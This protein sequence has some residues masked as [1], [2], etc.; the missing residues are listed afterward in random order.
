[1]SRPR[2]LGLAAA[3]LLLMVVVPATTAAA[4]PPWKPPVGARW[5]YQLNGKIRTDLCV[6]PVSGGAC[7]RPEVYDVDLYNM[8][9]TALNT[10]SVAQIHAAGAHAVCYVSAGSF[11]SFRPDAAAF[12]TS[13]KGKSNGWPGEKWLDIRQIP[14][15]LPI[16]A[17]R[18]DLCVAAG[19]DA[20][21]FD[22]V[23]GY[24]NDTGFP[25]TAS[26]QFAYN[27]VLTYVAHARGLSVGLK[28]DVEQAEALQ[29]YFDFAI[30]EQ[31]AQYS[32]CGVYDS[33]TA[34]GKAVLQVEYTKK[35][36]TFC[37]AAQVGGRSTIKKGLALK[38]KPW[39][40]CA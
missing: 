36:A 1:V 34:A 23:D 3:A 27:W 2:L 12:P 37:P 18:V 9:G 5:Q 6:V 4:A 8:D 10:V 38:A 20:V 15:L 40:P 7:V 17:A 25:L 31:C 29:P 11:E 35:P 26:D 19:F 14:V 16:I 39:A 28:N 13:V 32:E 21:E 33:W 22:N 24:T 30:N